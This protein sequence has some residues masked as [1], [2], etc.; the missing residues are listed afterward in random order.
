MMIASWVQRARW[1]VV[2]TAA[3]AA[4]G[5]G[6]AWSEFSESSPVA[7]NLSSPRGL[8]TAPN[9]ALVVT[10]Q[11]TGR[12]LEIDGSGRV[13][14]LVDGIVGA[15]TGAGPEGTDAAGVSAARYIDRT[16]FYITGEFDADGEAGYQTLYRLDA[17]G[18]V[19]VADFFAY[20]QANNTDGEFQ[21]EELLSNPYDLVASPGGGILVSDS[22]ANAVLHVDDSGEITPFAI[23]RQRPNPL[24]FGPPLMDQVPTGMTIGPDGAVY[25]AT[26]TGFP[27]PS[28]EARVYRM[29]D[30]NGDG[31]AQ[32]VGETTV[33]ASGLTTATDVAFDSDGSL[34]VTQ[35]SSD[36]LEEAP[37]SLVRVRNSVLTRV[38]TLTSPTAVYTRG[39]QLLVTQEFLGLV[40]E[41]TILPSDTLTVA[42]GGDFVAWIYGDTT[43]S[44]VFA[45]LEIAWLWENGTWVSWIPRF[46]FTDFALPFG[47]VLF[48]SVPQTTRIDVPSRP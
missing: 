38:A 20:E 42:G 39:N 43:A 47:S 10:E 30:A 32:D 19:A 4:L 23:F 1:L 45:D 2:A 16:L 17:G 8:S 15:T 11:G 36:M 41:I 24:S 14:V 35:F 18:P 48:I 25:V 26:L 3:I 31:D 37:G 9:G 22:G 5:V 21:P 46:G 12:I 44:A 6:M 13:S 28:G 40:S 7:T 29:Q 33:F 27:F 34:L